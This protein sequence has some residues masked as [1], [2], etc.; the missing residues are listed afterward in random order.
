MV[1]AN[2][3]RSATTRSLGTP[4]GARNGRP[5]ASGA[6]AA[7]ITS[8]IVILGDEIR[9]E[10]HVIK[11]GELLRPILQN[12]PRG[13]LA[14]PSRPGCANGTEKSAGMT[15]D[16]APFHGKQDIVLPGIAID[17]LHFRAEHRIQEPGEEG[18]RRIGT[19]DADGDFVCR[20]IRNRTY[21]HRVPD[22]DHGS[23]R[24]RR[25]EPIE[26]DGVVACLLRAEQRL[27]R[28][29]VLNEANYAAIPLGIVVEKIGGRDP[30]SAWHV[31]DD[32]YRIAGQVPA[33]VPRD[34]ARERVVAA[35]GARAHHDRH[36]PRPK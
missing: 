12:G 2:A 27:K 30:A 6:N 36:R 10:R 3:L 33:Y 22:E 9:S 25:A 34:H 14:E 23:L 24:A 5:S 19:G 7:C 28:R 35:S 13:L 1:S 32:K 18:R 26:L 17:G 29:V 16:L 11:L 21:R 20:K 15:I 31:S 4:G 8:P